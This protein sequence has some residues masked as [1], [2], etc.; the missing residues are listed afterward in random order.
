[1][2]IENIGQTI[3][4]QVVL[5]F[6]IGQYLIWYYLLAIGISLLCLYATWIHKTATPF[7]WG[8]SVSLI[9]IM[10]Q[11]YLSPVLFGVLAYDWATQPILFGL[12]GAFAVMWFGYI[13]LALYNL[14]KYG[15]VVM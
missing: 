8:L 6:D 14:I 15:K 11:T 3:A 12:T 4:N 1:M 9:I 7:F 2:L 5:T 13:G 10:L